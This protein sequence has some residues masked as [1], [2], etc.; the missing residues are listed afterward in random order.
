MRARARAR[1]RKSSATGAYN[2]TLRAAVGLN[3]PS[4][5]ARFAFVPRACLGAILRVRDVMQDTAAVPAAERSRAGVLAVEARLA[6]PKRADHA[7]RD[8]VPAVA[9]ARITTRDQEERRR[10]VHHDVTD[11]RGR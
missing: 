5:R 9:A 3:L 8:I 4:L 10:T 7:V 1:R 2:R 6:A 11:V